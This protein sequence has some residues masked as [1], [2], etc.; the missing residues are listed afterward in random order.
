[1]DMKIGAASEGN[2]MK[3]DTDNLTVLIEVPK[4]SR[5]K[6]EY[7]VEKKA[8]RLDRMLFSSVHYPSDYGFILDTLA[9]DG[10]SL[11]ALVL[12]WEPTFPGCIV[13]VK[14]IGLFR[15][16]DEGRPDDKILCVPCG[17]PDWQHIQ[18]LE[19]VPPHLLKEIGNFFA[20]YK[21]LESK[22]TG[23]HGWENKESAQRAIVESI[24]RYQEKQYLTKE[25]IE[26]PSI[27]CKD[28]GMTC[29]FELKDDNRDE[30][31]QLLAMH[32]EKTHNLKT[33]PPD[34]MQKIQK[35]IKE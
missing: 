12:T 9:E 18:K 4:G 19:D 2:Y 30:L 31:M 16:F 7:D 25:R 34:V 13:D 8:I 15:M 5:N 17:D 11:D 29:G 23:I 6:Y 14:P 35:A 1:M 20:I 33:I 21:E 26:M 10:D 27:K 32:A 3:C 28:I 22:K 24:M